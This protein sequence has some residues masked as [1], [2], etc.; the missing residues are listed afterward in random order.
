MAEFITVYNERD[1]EV[2]VNVDDIST[3]RENPKD[4]Q[5]SIITRRSC[6]DYAVFADE[7]KQT[8]MERIASLPGVRV[9]RTNHGG[10]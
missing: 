3:V 9:M 6:E 4:T 10:R 5:Q 8:V 2:L 1:G 7:L